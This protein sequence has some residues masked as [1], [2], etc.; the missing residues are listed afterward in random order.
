[1]AFEHS[2]ERDQE[3]LQAL[4]NHMEG[5]SPINTN[6]YA[7]VKELMAIMKKWRAKATMRVN[8]IE[9]LTEKILSLEKAVSSYD[10]ILE[11]YLYTVG[12][13]EG[14]DFLPHDL[15]NVT[16]PL[17]GLTLDETKILYEVAK[18]GRV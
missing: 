15:D 1:M 12:Q 3:V 5:G 18:R 13:C 11:Q 9:D 7:L 14:V 17:T 4:D 16:Q 2:P 10:A 8:K 6:V